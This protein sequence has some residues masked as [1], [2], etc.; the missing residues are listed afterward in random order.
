M[1]DHFPS[2]ISRKEISQN[3]GPNRISSQREK[4]GTERMKYFTA[5]RLPQKG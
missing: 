4:Q 2:V 5:G 3:L 1:T